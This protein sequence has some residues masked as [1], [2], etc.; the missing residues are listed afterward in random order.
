MSPGGE[1][2]RSAM[3]LTQ[4]SQTDYEELC[5]LDILGLAD[6]PTHDQ[7]TV[8]SEF[9]EQLTRDEAGW[10]ETGLPWRGNHATLPNNKQG[11]L[12]RL[13]HLTKRL[14]RDGLTAEFDS[15]IREQLNEGIVEI[16]PEVPKNKEFYIPHKAVV[17]D[18]AE[19][20]KT[21]IVY[22]ASAKANADEPSLNECLNPGP[23]L[24]NKL[25]DVLVQQRAYPV[26]VTAD[27]RKAFLQIRIRES[28]R[29]SLRFHWQKEPHSEI[30]VLRFTR[31]LFG[32]I[33][34]PFLLAGV[35]ECYFD[36][37]EKKYPDLIRELRRSLYVDD[38][39]TGG[40]TVLQARARKEKSIEVLNDATFHLHKWH[41]NVKELERDGEQLERD[42][43]QLERDGEQL[44]R[45]GQEL[46]K[47]GE[48]L[49][50]NDEQSFAK[51][52]LGVQPSETR[53]LG[54]KWNKA[55]DTL[56]I[57]FPE[58][59]H[60]VTRRGTL[61]KLAKIYDPLGLV[62]PLTLEGKLVYRAACES[63]TRWDANL[64]KK[65]SQRWENWER[66]VPKAKSTPR[67]IVDYREPVDELEL[68]AFGD[69]SKEGVGAAVYSIVRQQSGV[70]QRLVAGK[71]RLAKQGLTIPRLELVAARMA[72]NLVTNVSNALRGLPTPRVF[73]W[74][75]S[76]VALHWIRGDGQY[77]QFVANRVAKIQQ[78][79]EIEWRYVPT[80]DNPADLASRG[81]PITCLW[82]TGPEWL[83]FHDRWP[84]NPITEA[85]A[86]SE[87]EAKILKDVLCVAQEDVGTDCFDELLERH[88][89]RRVLRISAWVRR[90]GRN[91]RIKKRRS[92]PNRQGK[93]RQHGPL[94]NLEVNEMKIWWIKRV[95]LQD[96]GAPHH[97]RTKVALNLQKNVDGLLECRG[98]IQGKYP[99]YLP[100]KTPLTKKLVERVHVQTLHGGV[101]LTMAAVRED[102]WVPKLRRL[103]KSVRTSCPG[104]KRSRATA[105][106]A[107]PLA[108]SRKIESPEKQ[109]SKLWV[110]ILQDQYGT[111]E[112]VSEREKPTWS[113]SL[114]VFREQST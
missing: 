56:T 105:F 8:Y 35:L 18:S 13:N 36:A 90:F 81:G 66:I 69:A 92:F 48:Q 79:P 25:W 83:Q 73:G 111:A 93:Q 109:L 65:L 100:P 75:D 68:H 9:K 46:G 77:K 53:M 4:T 20:T 29:D 99:I 41:Y 89:L 3:L 74:L 114:A 24:Q 86:D 52:H 91:C 50:K 22:D 61:G 103:V 30:E 44:E 59:R 2:D 104:C 72:T 14:E 70:T 85:S 10:Y 106:S 80:H 54:L 76:S 78:H 98:R 55:E 108:N 87:A 110:L 27:I 96:S 49:G 16:A 88:D 26:V 47:V 43:E 112:L 113:F 45:D 23:S 38:L 40:H 42:G 97:E 34:S 51:Q 15:I 6:A 94:T 7:G 19:S 31:A 107:P 58:E 11:S 95:Q 71:G 32:L 82:W 5:R 60:P 1:F 84:S 39:L 101:G 12:R 63:K 37:W 64:D 62:S 102:Y 21:R 57:I 67:A 33:S 17:K 28:E